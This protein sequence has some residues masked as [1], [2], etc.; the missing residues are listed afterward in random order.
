MEGELDIQSYSAPSIV[1]LSCQTAAV[2]NMVS[3][4]PEYCFSG[5]QTSGMSDEDY[6]ALYEMW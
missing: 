2:Y 5:N 1:M 3:R 4:D 6:K